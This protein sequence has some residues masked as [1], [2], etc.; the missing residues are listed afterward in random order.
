LSGYK[1]VEFIEQIL[2]F[3]KERIHVGKA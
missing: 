1:P 3:G 2:N